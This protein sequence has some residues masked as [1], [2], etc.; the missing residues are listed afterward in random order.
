MKRFF[1]VINLM[2]VFMFIV[3]SCSQEV[4]I[5]IDNPTLEVSSKEVRNGEELVINLIPGEKTNV[6]FNVTFYFN[7]EEIGTVSD[8]P[9]QIT[10]KVEDRTLGIHSL[11]YEA[12]YKKKSGGSTS[13]AS[14]T[15]GILI[16]IVE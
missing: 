4:N 3:S 6:N 8:F 15:D 7:D 16:K 11:S 14:I 2:L 12:T 5:V 1:C 13:S 10:Y 9:Y